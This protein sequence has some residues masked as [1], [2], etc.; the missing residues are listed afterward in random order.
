M[1]FL[2][3]WIRDFVQDGADPNVLARKLTSAGMP[4]ET[5]TPLEGGD[6]LLD[7]EVFTNR[8]DC[9]NMYGMAREVA[10]ATGKRLLP[11]PGDVQE[12]AG[13]PAATSSAQV[14]IDEPPLCGRYTARVVRGVR[15]GPSP[16]WMARRLTA[17]GLRPI[18]NIVDITNYVLWELGHPLHAFDLATLRGAQVRVRR[19]RPGERLVTLDGVGREL[20]D[21]MLVIAD[22]DRAVALGGVMGGQATMVT[23]RT[24]DILL[25]SAYFDPVSVRRT[26]KRLGLSTDAS[27]RF[28]RGADI[29]AASVAIGRVA[30]LLRAHAGGT[31][32]PGL[33]DERS[34][35]PPTRRVKVR[36]SRTAVL[37]GMP[38]PALDVMGS[39]AALGFPVEATEG[40]ETLEVEVPSHRK[41]IEREVDLIEEV[42][43][44][45]GYDAVPGR[46]P[47]IAGTGGIDRPGHARE[48]R[49]R[50]SLEAAGYSQAV[51]LSFTSPTVDSGMRDPIDPDEPGMSPVE[52]VALT[53]PIAADQEILRTTLLPS[54]LASVAG[55]INRGV[56]DVRL[57][58]IGRTFRRAPSPPPTP[59]GRKHPLAGGVDEVVMLALA[60]TGSPRG[61]HWSEP[62]REASFYDLK[63]A[64]EEALREAGCPM[65]VEE[66]PASE[67]LD[68]GRRAYVA[69]DGRRLGRLGALATP[70]LQKLDLRQEVFVAEVSLS[71]LVRLPEA[72]VVYRQ[73]PRFPAVTR[74]LS[75]VVPAGRAYRELEAAVRGVAPDLVSRVHV[76]DRYEGSELPA[77]TSGLTLRVTLQH[78]DRTL[79][80]DE[81][82]QAMDK[83]VAAL[84]GDF[85]ISLRR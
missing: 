2:L 26:S 76:V 5:V 32:S 1:K 27:Y 69:S 62:P 39:L 73:L 54:L 31:V 42:A 72:A 16:D 28:E 43:R 59:D 61:R 63:G 71:A 85:G 17:L 48:E 52:P 64:L 21:S 8:P 38:L 33:I 66:M 13:A 74:D 36:P 25:E 82:Q 70:W 78:P 53:N 30:E 11:Y 57:Y 68:P 35:T 9:M 84:K 37:L 40:D 14:I 41:D 81:V 15:V 55:N 29:E 60:L 51:T 56:R 7:I 65:E 4:V 46:L 47:T 3:S 19:A 10:A 12:D 44:H 22:A 49:I 50:R 75:L 83:I 34:G 23:E 67:S 58:E 20:D 80:S 45:I 79:A 6:T 18:N 24:K 77:G